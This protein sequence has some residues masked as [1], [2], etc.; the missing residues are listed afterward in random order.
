MA[1]IEG[2]W[3]ANGY[4]V[5]VPTFMQHVLKL[6]WEKGSHFQEYFQEDS[7]WSASTAAIK[8]SAGTKAPSY[9]SGLDTHLSFYSEGTGWR[10]FFLHGH[11]KV[12]SIP[13][14]LQGRVAVGVQHTHWQQSTWWYS[15]ARSL[16]SRFTLNRLF[17]YL[18]FWHF[19]HKMRL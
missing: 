12:W 2:E 11:C 1:L 18:C 19:M 5:S 3:Q 14:R 4:K 8:R 6:K 17:K 9:L 13:P 10:G 7:H 15:P 16:T